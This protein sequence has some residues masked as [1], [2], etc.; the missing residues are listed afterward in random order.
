[1]SKYNLIN[2]NPYGVHQKIIELIGK[3]KKVLDVGC[4]EGI[5]SEKMK[6]NNCTVVGVEIDVDAAKKAKTYCEEL[7][8]GDVEMIQLNPKFENYFDI[9]VFA[10]ILEHLTNPLAVLKRF[11]RYLNDDGYVI[12]S[13]PNIANWKIR[14]QLLLGNFEY[15]DYGILDS[16]HLRFFNEKNTKKMIRDAGFKISKFDLTVGD[17]KRFSNIFYSM[18][19]IWPNMLAFQFLIIARKK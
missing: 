10:D 7:I 11:K 6:Q 12:I 15:D 13:L 1:M 2:T 5:L 17:V 19:M 3:N 16:G 14:L 8:I 18:G 9:I 4:F